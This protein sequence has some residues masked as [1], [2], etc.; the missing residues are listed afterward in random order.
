MLAN[1]YIAMSDILG[2]KQM[3]KDMQLMDVIRLVEY[4]IEELSPQIAYMTRIGRSPNNDR[5]LSRDHK[6]SFGKLHFSDTVVLWTSAINADDLEHETAMF[7]NLLRVVGDAIW[8]AL[9]NGVP[10]RAGLAFGESY[11]DE[12]KQIIA[13]QAVVDA[14]LTEQAQEWMGGAVHH[15]CLARPMHR[16]IGVHLVKYDVPTKP[17]TALSLR[18]AVDW[19][20][21]ARLSN[22]GSEM[23]YGLVAREKL[24]QTL[25]GQPNLPASVQHKYSNTRAFLQSQI[26]TR[27]TPESFARRDDGRAHLLT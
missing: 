1:R 14:Y 15:S 26:E 18:L 12:P 20:L 22:G 7:F 23:H 11:V 3:V 8:R 27:P 6:V 9:I 24:E 13:G 5:S 25:K 17:D 4:L 21:P 10:L 19:T 16:Y 2:F